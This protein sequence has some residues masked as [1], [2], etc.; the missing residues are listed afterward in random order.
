MT[1]EPSRSFV[2]LPVSRIPGK[3]PSDLPE[4]VVPLAGGR[5]EKRLEESPGVEAV[6]TRGPVTTLQVNVGKLC[7]QACHHCH[8]DAGPRRTEIMTD[9]TITRL[10]ELLERSP[11]VEVVDI[12]GGAPELCPGFERLVEGAT[13][14]GKKTIVRCNLTVIYEPGMEHLPDLYVRNRCQI[15]ASLPCYLEENVDRQRGSGTF[16]KSIDALLLLNRLGYGK[17]GTGLEL[18]LVYNPVGATLPPDQATLQA[19]Y[20]KELRA[21]YGIVFNDLFTIT[22]MPISRFAEQ[23]EREGRTEEYL[24]LLLE[25]YNPG[26]LDGLMCRSTLSISWEGQLYDCDFNQMLELPTE[27]PAAPADYTPRTIWDLEDLDQLVGR[28]IRTADHCLGCTAGSGS[29]CTGSLTAP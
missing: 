11:A 9:A 17:E 1:R 10:L 14:L 8:V 5:F 4:R 19:A 18:H 13:R 26:T 15:V 20:E 2:E 22:N 16:Q 28:R 7:N 27:D 12:T 24:A 23:L 29:S 6:L 3:C 21:R 25:S